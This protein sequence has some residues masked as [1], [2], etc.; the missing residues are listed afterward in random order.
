MDV[1][2]HHFRNIYWLIDWL[3]CGVGCQVIW[4]WI[5]K[6]R[7]V[8]EGSRIFKWTKS[9]TND[10]VFRLNSICMVLVPKIMISPEIHANDSFFDIWNLSNVYYTCICVL[11]Q[12][13]EFVLGKLAWHEI[14][15]TSLNTLTDLLFFRANFYQ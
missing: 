10:S 1:F 14:I 11:E 9:A 7:N 13:C 12:T 15:W 6:S 5:P 2:L 4:L 8:C 3:I